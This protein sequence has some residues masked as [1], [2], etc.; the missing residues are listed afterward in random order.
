[1]PTTNSYYPNR[2][3]DQIL[4]LRNYR[5]KLPN[6]KTALGYTDDD[7]TAIQADCDRLIWLLETFQEATQSFA[8]S[9]TAHIRLIQNGTGNALVTPARLQPARRPRAPGQ[10]PARGLQA[11]HRLHPQSQDPPRLHRFHRPRPR[12][13][14]CRTARPRRPDHQARHQGPAHDRRPCRDSMEET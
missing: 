1:M 5:N 6:H 14:R 8:Q 11:P 9:V 10:R 13:R 7:I 4:W 12:R 2:I 3:G